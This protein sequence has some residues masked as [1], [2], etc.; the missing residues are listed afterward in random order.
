M[1]YRYEAVFGRINY[2][3]ERE[4]YLEP[5]WPPDVFSRFDQENSSAIR[6]LLEQPGSLQRNCGLRASPLYVQFCKLRSSY[7]TTGSDA[8]G[9]YQYITHGM[10]MGRLL[11]RDHP[12]FLDQCNRITMVGE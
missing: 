3:W 1:A 7:G 2:N 5:E 8:S 4:I 12:L 9:D 6:V 11:M 10:L